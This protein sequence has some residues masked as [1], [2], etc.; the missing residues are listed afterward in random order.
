MDS[1]EFVLWRYAD[2]ECTVRRFLSYNARFGYEETTSAGAAARF[3]SYSGAQTVRAR[4]P[5]EEGWRLAERA[6]LLPPF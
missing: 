5:R 1:V 4:R 3:R 6:E 2:E